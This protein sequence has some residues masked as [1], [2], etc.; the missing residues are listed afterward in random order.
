MVQ[1]IFGKVMSTA[2]D[3]DVRLAG[4]EALSLFLLV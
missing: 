3:E 4:Q 2:M 1:A